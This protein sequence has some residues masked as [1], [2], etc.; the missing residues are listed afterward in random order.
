MRKTRER[1]LFQIANLGSARVLRVAE[2]L[3]WRTAGE[4]AD[5][6]NHATVELE[7]IVAVE[8]VVLAVVL[9]VQRDLHPGEQMTKRLAGI[10]SLLVGRVGVTSPIDVSQ[11]EVTRILQFFSS[12]KGKMPRHSC[13]AWPQRRDSAAFRSASASQTAL[14]PRRQVGQIMLADEVLF[15][16]F[17]ELQ[18][19]L[20]GIVQKAD[21][22][23]EGVA[24]KPADP[25][26]DVDAWPPS[27]PRAG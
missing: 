5:C 1:L 11:G 27:F 16:V 14:E 10:G 8:D 25:D 7:I 2:F 4:G 21:Q 24:K 23:R 17:V 3:P 18:R 15:G 22:V 12:I 26:H 19:H 13:R 9:I 20:D 6:G